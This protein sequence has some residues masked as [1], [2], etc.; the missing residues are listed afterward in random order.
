MTATQTKLAQLLAELAAA[1]ADIQIGTTEGTHSGP[2]NYDAFERID[3]T[4]YA[5]RTYAGATT[6][7]RPYEEAEQA[8]GRLRNIAHD[9]LA[10]RKA[11]VAEL[12]K[13]I[14]AAK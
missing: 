5:I 14:K 1:K 7:M 13:A 10:A 2:A 12:Q 4:R 8:D 3:G 11:R 9:S 6:G